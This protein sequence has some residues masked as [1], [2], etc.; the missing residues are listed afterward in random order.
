M[1][2][3][4]IIA[5]ISERLVNCE[6][7]AASAAKAI[8]WMS[9]RGIA[10]SVIDGRLSI[11]GTHP[12]LTPTLRKRVDALEAAIVSQLLDVRHPHIDA[13]SKF[14]SGSAQLHKGEIHHAEAQNAPAGFSGH[15]T[16]YPQPDVSRAP[17]RWLA[18]K[19]CEVCGSS[20]APWGI[21]FNFRRPEAARWFCSEHRQGG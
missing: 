15:P 10:L 4:E 21:G 19:R 20:D 6:D 5:D 16:A 14:A 2:I 13:T 11:A 7:K 17:A 18:E 12:Q 1:Q 8:R 3:I 9:D